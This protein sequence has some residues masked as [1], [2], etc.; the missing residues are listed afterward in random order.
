MKKTIKWTLCTALCSAF[1][2]PVCAMETI[3]TL[4]KK[5]AKSFSRS[6]PGIAALPQEGILASG[7][8]CSAV[9]IGH[10]TDDAFKNIT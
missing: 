5:S 4:A 10:M 1:C 7:Q 2:I 3:S 8:S 9:L 6:I